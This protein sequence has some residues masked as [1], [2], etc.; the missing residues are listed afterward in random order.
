MATNFKAV[1]PKIN[2]IK[3]P[4]V[5]QQLAILSNPILRQLYQAQ[6]NVSNAQR[7][8]KSLGSQTSPIFK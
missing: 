8:G 4:S 5:Q 2:S 3:L 1:S 7:V 6:R